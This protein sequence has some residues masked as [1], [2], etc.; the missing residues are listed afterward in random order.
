VD[1][2]RDGEG[3]YVVR[4]DGKDSITTGI[5]AKGEYM[6]P[7]PE[8]P[9]V[10][11]VVSIEK[12]RFSKRGE[13]RKVMMDIMMNGNYNSTIEN[14]SMLGSSGNEII[15]GGSQGFDNVSFPFICKVSY[16]SWNKMHSS[17]H[18]AK[19]E[20]VISEPGEWLVT[21]YN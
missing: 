14:L 21:I 20:F 16:T 11:G 4:I 8:P 10:L 1:G 15:M 9:I 18:Y 12:Y 2:Q 3:V 6:G 17:Q 19:F 7:A 5:W 13:G